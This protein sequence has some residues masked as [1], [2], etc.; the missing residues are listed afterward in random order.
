MQIAKAKG[1]HVLGTARAEKHDF[2]RSLGVDEPIDYT[3]TPVE[4]MGTDLDVVLDLIGGENGVRSVPL[5]R[6][7]G[8]VIPVPS[9]AGDAV[10]AAAKEAGVRATGILV[11]PDGHS[12]T[13]IA[14]LVDDGSIRVEIDSTYP[15][16]EAAK[17]HERGETGRA[18]GKIVLEVV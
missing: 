5:V 18:R 17:A 12:L 14:K 6:P 7:G 8:I 2:L 9:G 16:A 10:M 13:E 3:T 15:L 11:E 1:A 4:Q